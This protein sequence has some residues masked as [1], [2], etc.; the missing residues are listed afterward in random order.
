MLTW[1]KENRFLLSLILNVLLI[2]STFGGFRSA[3]DERRAGDE[4]AAQLAETESHLAASRDHARKLEGTNSQLRELAETERRGREDL[5]QRFEAHQRA[6]GEALDLVERTGAGID[7]VI[8]Q[9]RESREVSAA[10][11]RDVRL[12]QEIR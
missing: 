12:L 6:I 11:E 1:I 4:V 3:G 7:L 9:I 5:E 2:A 10:I 8:G